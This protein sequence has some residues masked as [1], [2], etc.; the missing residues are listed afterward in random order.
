MALL[1]AFAFRFWRFLAPGN[2]K[3]ERSLRKLNEIKY[4]EAIVPY[5]KLFT[6]AAECYLYVCSMYAPRRG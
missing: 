2:L 1:I 5:L 6:A 4:C 3:D